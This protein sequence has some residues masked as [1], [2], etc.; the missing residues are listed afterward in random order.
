MEITLSSGAIASM[1]TKLTAGDYDIIKEVYVDHIL[2]QKEDTKGGYPA[3][4]YTKAK[5]K[6]LSVAI[7]KITIGEKTIAPIT[8]EYLRGMDIPDIE[9]LELE[10]T[11]IKEF[12]TIGET[13][14][15]K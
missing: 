10:A 4:V 11:K 7:E 15:K 12:S 2:S 14:K 13:A 3:E 6:L 8:E 5:Y 9:K 1:K